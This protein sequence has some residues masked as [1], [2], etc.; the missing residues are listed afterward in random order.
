M[1]ESCFQR[2]LLPY[3][4]F[5][6]TEEDF[7]PAIYSSSKDPFYDGRQ[8]LLDLQDALC[9]GSRFA[10][11][12]V[13]EIALCQSLLVKRKLLQI[14]CNVHDLEKNERSAVTLGT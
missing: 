11:S 4:A 12:V 3:L 1:E 7:L 2:D 10:E 13:H 5:G 8:R 14:L 6:A 9:F